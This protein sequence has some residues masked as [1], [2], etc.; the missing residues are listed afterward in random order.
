[1]LKFLAIL[2]DFI[3]ISWILYLNLLI[4]SS[5]SPSDYMMKVQQENEA[6]RKELDLKVILL[7]VLSFLL[8]FYLFVTFNKFNA[9]IT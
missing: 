4:E 7:T 1:M 2:C 3:C 6:L 5:R 9:F 8:L